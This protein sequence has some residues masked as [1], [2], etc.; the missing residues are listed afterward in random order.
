LKSF[1]DGV[2]IYPNDLV[3]E[4]RKDLSDAF[5][6]DKERYMRNNEQNNV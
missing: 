2:S 3:E 1:D 6:V 4:K 5:E